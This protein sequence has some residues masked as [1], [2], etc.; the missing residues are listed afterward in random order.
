MA[1]LGGEPRTTLREADTEMKGIFARVITSAVFL[2]IA[3]EMFAGCTTVPIPPTYT[4]QELKATCERHGGA[5]HD[6]DLMGGFCEK[7]RS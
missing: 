6:D 1:I 5:W 4:Q 3:C 7:P 2:S